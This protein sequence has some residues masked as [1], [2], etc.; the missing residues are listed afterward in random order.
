VR[1]VE[2]GLSGL[3]S[4]G[5]LAAGDRIVDTARRL[6]RATAVGLGFGGGA[7][8]VDSLE[9]QKSAGRS[10]YALVNPVDVG[11]ASVSLF[12]KTVSIVGIEPVVGGTLRDRIIHG[13]SRPDAFVLESIDA[14][15]MRLI[16]VGDIFDVLTQAVVY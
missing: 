11:A 13:S 12:G 10:A 3:G 7:A 9:V 6:G 5:C 1:L 16:S 8:G 4:G 15:T 14:A 2:A